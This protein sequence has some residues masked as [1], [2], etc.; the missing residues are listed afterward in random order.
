MEPGTES[1]GP[2]AGARQQSWWSREGAIHKPLTVSG[3]AGQAVGL[4]PGR[5]GMGAS[6]HGG[7][8][9]GVLMVLSQGISYAL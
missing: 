5:D 1:Y 7:E 8:P 2:N 9:L 6:N 4:N 3:K